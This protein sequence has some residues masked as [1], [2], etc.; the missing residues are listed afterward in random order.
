VGR[1]RRCEGL[2]DRENNRIQIFST[3][4][5]FIAI[6][7]G[8][9]RPTDMYVDKDNVMYV[10]EL[11][12][13]VSIVDLEGNLIGRF[14]SE[15]SNAPAKFWG[16]HAIWVDSVGDM[17]VGEVLDGRRIQSSPE[18]SSVPALSDRVYRVQAPYQ[19]NAVHLY[20]VRGSKLALIDSGASDSPL[21]AVEPA[22]REWGLGWSD[23]DYLFNTH[24]HA[25]HAGGNGDL[26]DAAP[27]T[28]IGI[29]PADAA[30]LGGPDAHL[31]SES[32]ASAL[33]RL[34]GRD[35]MV[36]GREA[37]LRRIVGHSVG[38]DRELNDGDTIDLGS[39]VRLRV[40]HTPGHTGGSVCF[41]WEAGGTVFSGDAVQ[42]HGWRSGLAPIYHDAVYV[43]SLDRIESLRAD[44]LC[45]G[46]T[47]GWGGVSNDPVRRGSDINQTLQASRTASAA[48]D[49]AAAQALTQL[50][51]EA[52]F[53]ELAQAA[54]RELVFDLPILFERRTIVPP[55]AAGAI[56]A[57]LRAHG[58]QQAA[59]TPAARKLPL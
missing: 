9:E 35:D 56:R 28:Q 50:G 37:T 53:I 25:D 2:L 5:E 4:G 8:F 23:L 43:Q 11:E 29:H 54:F 59:A 19:G 58:W 34:M 47:F 31:R 49:R 44:T 41:F 27:H 12:D 6:W 1:A 48:I 10:S 24:G 14:G 57:H 40:V 20:L 21:A 46:H 38:V 55:A 30:L 51:P 36:A 26:K 7:T 52:S 18:R 17:Y 13:H 33:M 45:M 15:R 42:G 22:L 3:D 39:D 16:P 32:D